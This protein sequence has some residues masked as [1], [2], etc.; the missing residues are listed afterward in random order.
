M[1]WGD[2]IHCLFCHGRIPFY[3]KLADGQFCCAA[4]RKAYW[5]EQDRLAVELLHHN[6]EVLESTARF[7]VPDLSVPL[8]AEPEP[9]APEEPDNTPPLMGT[10]VLPVDPKR[11]QGPD[12]VAAEPL[13]FD[14]DSGIWSVPSSSRPSIAGRL[15]NLPRASLLPYRP[16]FEDAVGAHVVAALFDAAPPDNRPAIPRSSPVAPTVPEAQLLRLPGTIVHKAETELRKGGVHPLPLLPPAAQIG[17][18]RARP[19]SPEVDDLWSNQIPEPA[20]ILAV[21]RIAARSSLSEDRRSAGRGVPIEASGRNWL[22]PDFDRRAAK[23]AISGLRALPL[24]GAA[25]VHGI[26]IRDLSAIP[27]PRNIEPQELT[28]LMDIPAARLVPSRPVLPGVAANVPRVAVA[29]PEPVIAVSTATLPAVAVRVRT[30]EIRSEHTRPPVPRPALVVP[31]RTAPASPAP[32]PATV[33]GPRVPSQPL[34]PTQG[35]TEMLPLTMTAEPASATTHQLRRSVPQPPPATPTCPVSKLGPVEPA[36]GSDL[37]H[38]PAGGRR[39]PALPT[40]EFR[41]VRLSLWAPVAGFWRDAPRDLKMLALLVP[42]LIGLVIHPTLPAVRVAAGRTPHLQ[43]LISNPWQRVRQNVIQR[44][45]LEFLEDFRTGLDDWESRSDLT[46]AWSYDAAGFVHPGPLALYRPSIGLNDY[47]LQF[48][49]QIQR[50]GLGWV[51]RASDLDNYYAVKLVVLKPGPLPTIELRRWAVIDGKITSRHSLVLRIG[52]RED[53]LYRVRMDVHGNDYTVYVQGQLADFWS[54]RR[55][56]SGG[57]GF[58]CERGED[59]RI[60]WLQVSYQYD[61]LGRLC[62]FLA[63]YDMQSTNRSWKR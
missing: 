38:E 51:F 27:Y 7:T 34:A 43:N 26:W 22:P 39:R 3:R 46:A 41:N 10:I 25:L 17:A 20:G 12:L 47:G 30:V 62:A 19:A 9:A 53:T 59:A 45:G 11:D 42:L 52:A 8:G 23:L 36:P 6:H 50:K 55:L 13:E 60:G 31:A 28:P 5:K 58:F 29:E 32:E 48:L 24:E 2:D 15:D 4:H 54:D 49:G 57:V 16:P 33:L 1:S 56:Q 40:I 44:A 14:F 37:P 63:P 35:V 61:A 18:L 21:P